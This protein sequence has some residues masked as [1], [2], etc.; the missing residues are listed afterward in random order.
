MRVVRLTVRLSPQGFVSPLVV[1]I[2][3]PSP[4]PSPPSVVRHGGA[5]LPKSRARMRRKSR[6]GGH[7]TAIADDKGSPSA[8]VILVIRQGDHEL[9]DQTLA[10]HGSNGVSLSQ[11]GIQD[12][13][14][15]VAGQAGQR[16]LEAG[17]A[18][19]CEGARAL[20]NQPSRLWESGGNR[21]AS[22]Q[23]A[24][25]GVKATFP[26]S[27]QSAHYAHL[28]F[29]GRCVWGFRRPGLAENLRFQFCSSSS[30]LPPP[31]TLLLWN[32]CRPRP[33]DATPLD[34]IWSLRPA[35]RSIVM[36]RSSTAPS[37]Q[38]CRHSILLGSSLVVF[39]A[40]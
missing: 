15:R 36:P 14:W 29:V 20:S 2:A 17:V 11:S 22:E 5:R 31:P 24:K 13:S 10:T 21:R 4:P 34:S 33:R 25:A 12:S 1:V 32:T 9:L 26:R 37:L 38:T 19:R 7:L 8:L 3:S 39:S 16:E 23:E 40:D 6:R 35:R 30:I 28:G 27:G 18:A